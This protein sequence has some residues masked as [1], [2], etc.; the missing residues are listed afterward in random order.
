MSLVLS[1]LVAVSSA[2]FQTQFLPPNNLHLEDNLLLDAN[3]T[4]S[5]FNEI[6]TTVTNF[7]QPLAATKGAKIESVPNWKST[8]VNASASRAGN[9]WFI[10]MYGGLARRP[11]TTKDGFALVVCHEMGHHFAGFPFVGGI[12]GLLGGWAANEGQSDYFATQSCARNI[13]KN[14]KKQNRVL[15]EE[16]RSTLPASVVDKCEV[17]W[18]G[19]DNE[20]DT[21]ENT[22]LCL[23]VANAG[24][25]LGNLLASLR[26]SPTPDY[27]TPDTKQVRNTFSSHPAAQCRLDTYLVGALC[28]K[29]FD[30]SK[31]PGLGAPWF[32]KQG[33][34]E[35]LKNSCSH[36]V[37]A[38][39]DFARPRCWFAPKT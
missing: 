35:A 8:T 22:N 2:T 13:W 25:S 4:E 39:A 12:Q 23:R 38:E 24:Q 1:S 29:E 37:E 26:K 34:K 9:T 27:N 31:I 19:V 5:E 30:S 10:N 14:E 33:E 36:L 11:E 3:M 21:E 15:A 20:L 6:I 32:T 28:S 7:Y 17:T 16:A 18:K